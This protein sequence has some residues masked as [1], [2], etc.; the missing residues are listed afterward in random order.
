MSSAAASNGAHSG[1]GRASAAGDGGL[2]APSTFWCYE[3]DMSVALAVSSPPLRCPHCGGDFLEEMEE[4]RRGPPHSHFRCRPRLP[5][6]LGWAPPDQPHGALGSD[7]DDFDAMDDLEDTAGEEEDEEAFDRLF[8]RIVSSISEDITGEAAVGGVRAASKS[9]VEAIPTVRITEASLAA[10][11]CLLCAVCKEEFALRT[12][13]RRLPC[14]HI[15]HPD[16]ILP[17]LSQHNSCPL[18]RFL[19]PT[20]DEERRR[21]LDR[22]DRPH[23]ALGNLLNALEEDMSRGRYDFPRVVM[24]NLLDAMEQEM[25]RDL[26]NTYDRMRSLFPE[27][28]DILEADDNLRDIEVIM[29]RLMGRRRS[30]RPGLSVAAASWPSQF[31]QSEMDSR[32]VADYPDRASSRNPLDEVRSVAGSGSGAGGSVDEEG[33]VVMSE[34]T[35]KCFYA[36]FFPLYLPPFFEDWIVEKGELRFCA[37]KLGGTEVKFQVALPSASNIMI[38]WC[39]DEDGKRLGCIAF[40]EETQ[41]LVHGCG[42]CLFPK[43]G[44]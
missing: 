6:D 32:V 4:P 35:K 14:G 16:C 2:H 21:S 10:D 42:R 43:M 22:A 40:P 13:A 3:C 36:S 17:W 41:A 23:V 30:R 1:S 20:E 44:E 38:G 25:D 7:D 26:R 18:C 11:P 5:G 12:E 19:L 31:T 29:R 39:Q 8:N 37:L 15:Y 27:N 33:D 24:G 9:A 28:A 34:E